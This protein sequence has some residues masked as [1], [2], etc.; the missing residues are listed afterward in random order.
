MSQANVDL[1]RTTF[2]ETRRRGDST[3]RN[4]AEYFD[5]EVEFH[6]DPRLPEAGIYRGFKEV[7]DYWEQFIE[8]FDEFVFEAE[9]FVDIGGARVLVLLIITTRGR[10]SSANVTMRI[11]WIVTVREARITRIEA[12]ADRA[13]ALEAVGLSK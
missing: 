7:L 2:D 12:F 11:A 3:P 8:N 5:P 4:L 6:E 13:E 9:D 10:G 1:V